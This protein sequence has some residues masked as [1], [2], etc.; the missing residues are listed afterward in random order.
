[1]TPAGRITVWAPHAT[2]VDVCL[3]DRADAAHETARLPLVRT[4]D[5]WTSGDV[6]LPTGQLY[7]LRADGPP[8]SGPVS[9]F[10]PERL[11]LDPYARAVGRLPAPLDPLS[12]VG[13][14]EFDWRGD[15][16]PNRAWRDTVIYEAHVRGLTARHPDVARELRGT[17]LG[18]SSPAVIAHLVAL[19]VTA[20]ELLPIHAHADEPGLRARGL[21]NYWGY[22]T[23]SFFAPDPRFATAAVHD[24][25]LAAVRECKTMVREL[26]AAGIEVVLDVVFNHT[27]E[28]PLGGPTLSLRGLDPLDTYRRR[29]ADPWTYDDWT[30][31]GNTLNLDNPAMRRLVFASLRY[32][33]T[34]MHVDGFR[35]DLASAIDRQLSGA[36]S[37]FAAMRVDPVL[38]RVK[39]IAEP[40]DATSEGYRLGGFPAGIAEWNGRYRDTVRR[41]WRGDAGAAPELATRIC[42]SQDLFGAPGRSAHD[43]INFVTSHDGFTLADLVSYASKHNDAN[44]EHNADGESNNFSSNAGIE[45]PTADAHII[46]ARRTRQRSLIA[47]LAL[48]RGVPMLSGGDELG[49]TQF[50]NNNAYCH[51]GPL[52]WT[53]WPG[54]TALLAFVQRAFAVRR[55]WPALR[56]ETFFA[57]TDVTWLDADASPLDAAAWN[58]HER[59]ALGMWIAPQSTTPL[60]IYVNAGTDDVTYTLP[61]PREWTVLLNSATQE[62]DSVA[63]TAV[64]VAAGALVVLSPAVQA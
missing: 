29:P 63:Q 1:M 55:E 2:H 51:D 16:A 41:F 13:T 35:F 54:D 45:G 3:F 5:H 48:S 20:V 47:T 4:G 56:G 53:P 21:T 36:E 12:V 50:G 44:G 62:H 38:S 64:R 60:L 57:P 37:L 43:S 61:D 27:A 8:A 17:F 6:M 42:G 58:T 11:L 9:R 34:E 7:A 18:V 32:W 31:C 22:N 39:L 40:W 59:R 26:H 10:E 30:G 46:A 28:G 25:P 49:R 19:G 24:D 52:T 14:D 23:L 15:T 33:V